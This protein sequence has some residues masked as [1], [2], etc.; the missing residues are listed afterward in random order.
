MR[1]LRFRHG[2]D[3]FHRA[4]TLPRGP[5]ARSPA[6]RRRDGHAVVQPRHS[7][8][9]VPR[10]ARG[11]TTGPDRRDPPRISRSG[12]GR[13]R[14]GHL[15]REP[16]PIGR[17]RAGRRGANVQPPRSTAGQ[18]GPRRERARG[19]RRWFD[20]TAPRPDTWPSGV[21]RTD[22]P[23]GL[24]RTGRGPPRGRGRPVRDRDLL[25]ARAPPAR[26]RRSTKGLGYPDHRGAHVR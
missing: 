21:W 20:R 9:R 1:P 19:P 3:D 5:G 14:D 26:R 12:R 24:P 18:R 7:P 8:A 22:H 6:L 15:W 10:R 13:D 4:A 23:R 16:N 2:V 11:H 17:L 25:R